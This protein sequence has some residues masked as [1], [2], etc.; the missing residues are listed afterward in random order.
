MASAVS[1]NIRKDAALARIAG[2]LNVD[3]SAGSKD[4]GIAQAILLERIADAAEVTAG[5]LDKYLSVTPDEQALAAPPSLAAAIIHATDEDLAAFGL[6]ATAIKA[7]R[8]AATD[9]V[10]PDADEEPAQ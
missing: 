3:T 5:A 8:K 7:A 1:I 4:P 2:A 10:A 9:A 6:S